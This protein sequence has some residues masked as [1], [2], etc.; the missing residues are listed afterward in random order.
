MQ[1]LFC[2]NVME[3]KNMNQTVDNYLLEGCGR[4]HLGGT[5]DC[6]VHKWSSILKSL[7]TIV[8]GCGLVEETK[9]GVPC[10]T[11][12]DRNV[13]L[14]S[15]FKEYCAVSFFKGVL[16]DDPKKILEKP[17]QHSQAVRLIKITNI[18]K[19][20][21]V[22]TELRA[23]IHEAIEVEKLGLKVPFKKSN[24][25]IPEELAAKFEED[26][27]FKTAFDALTP[28]RQRAYIIHF[29]TPKQS[30][31]RESRIDKSVE[32]ILNGEGINDKYR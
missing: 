22:E 20:G 29:S 24:G 25:P 19:I 12:Q 16:L 31:T 7:R 11:F 14:L 17:G 30:K 27:T 4:C 28:G 13:L 26:I 5:P 10:Y 18:E 1:S 23:Y 15:A 32:K 21:V 2:R 8:L 6:K 9:W 3:Y